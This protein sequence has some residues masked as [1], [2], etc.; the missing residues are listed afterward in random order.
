MYS[1]NGKVQLTK[2]QI[3]FYDN[4]ATVEED[5][6]A[7]AG[8]EALDFFTYTKKPYKMLYTNYDLDKVRYVFRRR[9]LFDKQC[10]EIVFEN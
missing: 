8:S 9:F 5:L 1:K 4:L 10:I 3:V 7:S 2:S 6:A